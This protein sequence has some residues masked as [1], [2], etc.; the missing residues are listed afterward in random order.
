MIQWW[1]PGTGL[2]RFAGECALWLMLVALAASP[3][4]SVRFRDRLIATIPR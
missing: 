2:V 4:L 3:M 1:L